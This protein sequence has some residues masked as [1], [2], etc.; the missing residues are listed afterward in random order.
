MNYLTKV[1]DRYLAYGDPASMEKVRKFLSEKHDFNNLTPQFIKSF[2]LLNLVD[3][4]AFHLKIDILEIQNEQN[5]EKQII[6]VST[7]IKAVLLTFFDTLKKTESYQAALDFLNDCEEK[8]E[9]VNNFQGGLDNL[10]SEIPFEKLREECINKIISTSNKAQ[11]I[12]QHFAWVNPHLNAFQLC[13]TIYRDYNI[14]KAPTKLEKLFTGDNN[15]HIKVNQ[16]KI[17]HFVFLVRCL[18]GK[19][20][21]GKYKWVTMKVNKGCWSLLAAVTV[22]YSGKKIAKNDSFFKNLSLAMSEKNENNQFIISEIE[23][24]LEE[25]EKHNNKL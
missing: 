9:F 1:M 14:I 18:L 22:N 7:I 3:D 12:R 23:E 2:P 20:Y 11:T 24:L 6:S 10:I 4:V 13:D 21:D 19:E 5:R 8:L 16:D 17:G 25:L 15:V